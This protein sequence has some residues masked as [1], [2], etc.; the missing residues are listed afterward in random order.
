MLSEG[1]T[2][3]AVITTLVVVAAYAIVVS[4][5]WGIPDAK[6]FVRCGPGY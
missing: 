5:S 4:R 2:Y 6:S 3:G 1:A